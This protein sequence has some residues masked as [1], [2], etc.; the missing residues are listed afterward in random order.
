MPT[1]AG[2]RSR[3]R[4]LPLKTRPATKRGLEAALRHSALQAEAKLRPV[5]P[6]QADRR[7]A[8]RAVSAAL[9]ARA[10]LELSSGASPDLPV[11]GRL[12][13]GGQTA[14]RFRRSDERRVGK[15]CGS[16]CR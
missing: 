3:A 8:D 12:S 5:A 9:A 11:W 15:E 2:Y 16:T 14:V 4:C 13:V 6:R 10:T 1:A 7:Q